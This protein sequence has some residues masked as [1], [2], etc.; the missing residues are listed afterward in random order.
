M[1]R[2]GVFKAVCSRRFSRLPMIKQVGKIAVLT[3]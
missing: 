1:I 2:R 3:K